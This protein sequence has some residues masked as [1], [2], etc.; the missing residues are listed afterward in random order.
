ME[1]KSIQQFE[2]DSG[3]RDCKRQEKSF[4]RDIEFPKILSIAIEGKYPL[5]VRTSRNGKWYLKGYSTD[6]L[7]IKKRVVE[8]NEKQWRKCRTCFLIEYEN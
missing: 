7:D 3:D 4:D 6:Y 5:I 2:T 8:N 1:F